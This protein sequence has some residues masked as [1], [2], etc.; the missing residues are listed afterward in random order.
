MRFLPHGVPP[1]NSLHVHPVSHFL[2]HVLPT[3]VILKCL[4]LLASSQFHCCTVD[5]ES[6]EC[7]VLGSQ[8]VD[9]PERATVIHKDTPV[10]VTFNGLSWERTMEITVNETKSFMIMRSSLV[11]GSSHV[12]SKARFTDRTRGSLRL[13]DY[14]LHH[15]LA[16]HGLEVSIVEVRESPVPQ[17]DIQGSSSGVESRRKG[18]WW[19]GGNDVA[20]QMCQ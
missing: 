17:R 6:L 14:T 5:L 16:D 3:F 15:I 12:T 1:F 7:L 13:D 2:R 20:N 11:D 19:R 18:R 9:G 4:H 10:S 8:K